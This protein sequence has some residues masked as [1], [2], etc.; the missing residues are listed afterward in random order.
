MTTRQKQAAFF[1]KL[2]WGFDAGKSPHFNVGLCHAASMMGDAGAY[3]SDGPE[4]STK[5]STWKRI[6]FFAPNDRMFWCF[7]ET[8]SS[9]PFD[10]AAHELRATVAAFIAAMIETGDDPGNE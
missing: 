9:D 10:R 6:Q 8:Q 7:D 2:S 5:P 4:F 1:R 3:R